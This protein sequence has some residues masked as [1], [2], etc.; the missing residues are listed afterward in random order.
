MPSIFKPFQ[1]A[2]IASWFTVP[3]HRITLEV[4][5]YYETSA[6]A[7]C[8]ECFGEVLC[9]VMALNER[10]N[11]KGQIYRGKFRQGVKVAC[12]ESADLPDGCEFRVLRGTSGLTGTYCY[13]DSLNRC[14]EHTREISKCSS[15]P[16]SEVENPDRFALAASVDAR[17]APG[18]VPPAS[19]VFPRGLL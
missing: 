3:V 17:S 10:L 16:A 9:R 6:R 18:V 2:A 5:D 12:S 8:P 4:I 15:D 19:I 13:A 7:K 11:R 14:P 1:Q